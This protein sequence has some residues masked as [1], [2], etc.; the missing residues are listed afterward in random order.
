M[1][2][3]FIN[4][5]N[6]AVK[7]VL[8]F[9]L[10]IVCAVTDVLI[11]LFS[12]GAFQ[13]FKASKDFEKQ[14][15]YVFNYTF[16]FGDI[17]D[18]QEDSDGRILS[19]F[20]TDSITPVQLREVLDKLDDNSKA[21]MPGMYF[22]LMFDQ[23]ELKI[24]ECFD[25]G[26]PY[27]MSAV[28]IQ[29]DKELND[30]SLYESYV[31]NMS[32][33]KGRYFTKEEYASDENLVVLP[34]GAKDDMI[35]KNVELLGKSYKVIGIFGNT[36]QEE[37]QVPFK[38]L[39]DNCTIS[40][41]SFLDDNALDTESF[42]KLKKAFSEV[43]TCNVNFPPIETIDMAEI[44]FYNSVIF[45]SV[46]VAIASAINLAMLFRYIIRSRAKQ[47]AIFML[48]GCTSNK[49]RRMYIAEIGMISVGVND[50]IEEVLY[51][52]ADLVDM[53][54]CKTLTDVAN[55]LTSDGSKL[56]AA[57]SKLARDL[58][59]LV[60]T[61]AANIEAAVTEVKSLNRSANV[62][63]QTVNNPL[64]VDYYGMSGVSQNRKTVI[65]Y[66]YQYLDVSLEGGNVSGTGLASMTIADNAGL[67]DKIRGLQNVSA[68]D[69]Y[70]P[71]VGAT[72]EK[73][74]GFEFSNI[75]DLNMTFT[76]L[77]QVMLAS[78]AIQSS[79]MLSCGDGSVISNAYTATGKD[80][81]LKSNRP[82]ADSIITGAA[83]HQKMACSMG[84][85]DA[86][87]SI[88]TQDLFLCLY[89]IA[90][91]GAGLDT[92]LNPIQRK[93]LD[94]DNSGTL[95]SQDI[96]LWLYYMAQT[97]AGVHVDLADYLAQNQA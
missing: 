72:G 41:I 29:Y 53:D 77:G 88:D 34:S 84:D 97:G 4:L 47:T 69:F 12:H 58:P 93:A 20:G 45:M 68:A 9:I 7:N 33:R 38:T 60:E 65:A 24:D 46:A 82:S 39:G 48:C 43:L 42:F 16:S 63:V 49:I 11:I 90:R 32:I 92:E 50:F 51:K 19:Y 8:I 57:N 54:N 1:K 86:S 94:A 61:V 67:N 62:V 44:K 17:I 40:S 91:V 10:F 76:P 52:N 3:V 25:G 80:G 71:Y 23:D 5:K 26:Q 6:F 18:T 95:D 27:L 35:G 31:D 30:Y 81:D 83:S 15:K 75:M 73:A 96:F 66:L 78:A 13:N 70:T 59:A 55:K 2:Y 85:A 37:F 14:K 64:G 79:E 56:S 36:V 74:I 28:R 87:G 89:N 21:S 22:G